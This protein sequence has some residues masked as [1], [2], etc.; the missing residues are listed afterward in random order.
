[1]FL[2]VAFQ[3]VLMSGFP[4]K[5]LYFF[6]SPTVVHAPLFLPIDHLGNGKGTFVPTRAMKTYGYW[7]DV[8]DHV[9]T[10]STS[11]PGI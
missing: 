1:V 8:W 10:P 3:V 5:I 11:R 9:H 4:A 6:T 2:I 7:T